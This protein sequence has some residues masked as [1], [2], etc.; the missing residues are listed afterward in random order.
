MQVKRFSFIAKALLL[1]QI[2]VLYTACGDQEVE[3]M[4]NNCK[5]GAAFVQSIGFDVN[6]SAFSTTDTR[7]MGLLLIQQD[8]NGQL[9]KYQHPSWKMAGWTGPI[10]ID[11]EGNCFVGPVPV[12]NVLNNPLSKQNTVYKVNAT[13]G[14][15]NVFAQLPVTDTAGTTNPYGILGFTYLC[16]SNVLFVSSV[17]GSDRKTQRGCIYAINAA[18]GKVI[19]KLCGMDAF[20]MGISYISGKR[21]LYFGN[22]RTTDIYS[23]TIT[24]NGKFD[25]DKKLEFSLAD[26]GPRG[27]DKARKIRFE[28]AGQMKV[29]GFEFNYNL[30]APTEKQE[31][32]YTFYWNED[33]KK[34]IYIP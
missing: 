31:T 34:W 7:Q 15:M 14:E 4:A 27:D 21:K 1:L 12:V 6:R 22:A 16:E 3:Y 19:D 8:Q 13:T 9:K 17:M 26:L 20:G 33:E 24:K 10:Q 11:A 5:K 29:S 23:V 25:G 18:T 30:T 2:V 32:L 28:K